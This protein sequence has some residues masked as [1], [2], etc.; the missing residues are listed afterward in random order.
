M[1]AECRQ[2]LFIQNV[3][4]WPTISDIVL[5]LQLP[6]SFLFVGNDFDLPERSFGLTLKGVNDLDESPVG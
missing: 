6:I 5:G 2:S 4:R 3:G 1:T